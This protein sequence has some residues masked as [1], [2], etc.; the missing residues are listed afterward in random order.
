MC[1]N[2]EP[3]HR[4]PRNCKHSSNP[5]RRLQ[6]VW[7]VS[8]SMTIQTSLEP[9]LQLNSRRPDQHWDADVDLDLR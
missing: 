3:S 1:S 5:H 7:V 9:D 6:R 2:D 8:I 4:I